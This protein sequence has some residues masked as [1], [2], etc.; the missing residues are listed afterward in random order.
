M[1]IEGNIVK[2]LGERQVSARYTSFDYCFN[3]FQSFR[4]QDRPEEIAAHENMQLSCL[5]LGFF[6][7]SWGMFRASSRL[8]SKNVTQF[9]PL[10]QVIAETPRN[11]WE[12]DA[13]CYSD[14][15]S[16]ALIGLGHRI[17]ATFTHYVTPTLITKIILGVY[18]SVPA[19]DSFVT[20]G[21]RKNGLPASFSAATLRKLGR[22][23]E[24]NAQAIDRQ[25]TTT[26]D[27][28]TGQLTSR[29]YT[30]AKV[31]DM[32]FF[33]EGGGRGSRF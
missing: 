17:E 3:Y 22:Y 6:L 27:F 19:L 33:I 4:D 23:Y 10:V 11:V 5:Q 13:N 8:P 15:N 20:K 26:Y 18:G 14:E 21:L 2:F 16:V 1:D 24:G 28:D 30:R 7:A 9:R 31:I 29:R 32:A 25:L 12:I